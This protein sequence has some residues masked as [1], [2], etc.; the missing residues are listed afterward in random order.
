MSRIARKVKDKIV[1]LLIRRN[2]QVGIMAEWLETIR[3]EGTPQWSP[4]SPL[5]SNVMLDDLDKEIER[6]GQQFVRYADDCN[7][8]VRSKR[9]GERVKESITKFQREP[10]KLKVNEA[11]SAVD[12]RWNRKF[13]GYSMIAEKKTRLK[14]APRS[15]ERLKD[16]LR[17]FFVKVSGSYG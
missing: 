17:K 1:L 6:R 8:Y 14:I 3:T 13:L 10:L 4:L 7:I 12:R 11:K 2:L 15:L 9:A 16:N 5:L